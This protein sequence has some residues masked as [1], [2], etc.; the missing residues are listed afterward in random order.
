MLPTKEPPQNKRSTQ[1]ENEGLEIIYQANKQEKKS[2]GS[3]TH[4]RQNRL[5]KKRHKKRPRWS[6]HNIQGNPSRRHKHCKYICY[7]H[8]STQTHKQNINNDFHIS[9]TSQIFGASSS[10][11]TS[12]KNSYSY[13]IEGM[14]SIGQEL[15]QL[16]NY[17]RFE[18]VQILTLKTVNV[19]L[20]GTRFFAD[21][22]VKFLRMKSSW[23]QGET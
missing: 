14:E 22:V 5:Q 21:V 6:L 20:F 10:E 3:N 17:S 9:S 16:S 4:I 8:R 13:F 19:I 11:L 18:Y 23:I 7:Q 12:R 1:T 15:P 2:W